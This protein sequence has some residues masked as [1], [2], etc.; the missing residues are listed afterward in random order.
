MKN[1]KLI[2]VMAVLSCSC[3]FGLANTVY[4]TSH[5]D[6]RALQTDLSQICEVSPTTN[7]K[8]STSNRGEASSFTMNGQVWYAPKYSSTDTIPFYRLNSGSDHMDS[9]LAGEG[10]FATEGVLAYPWKSTAKPA[11]TTNIFRGNNTS[12]SDH[13]LMSDYLIFPGYTREYIQNSYAYPRFG[14]NN[15]L[16]SLTGTEISLNSNLNTGGAV[17]EYWWNGKQF[18]DNFDYG[19]EM[20]SAIGFQA[21]SDGNPTEAGDSSYDTNKNFMHG[22]PIA[23]YSNTVNSS[24]K[25]QSTRA[26]PLE[27]NYRNFNGNQ[28][29]VPVVYKDIKLGKD[30]TIDDASLNLGTG[31]DNLKPKVAK[32]ETFVNTSTAL[33]NADTEIPTAYLKP[34][35]NR[36]FSFD[37]TVTD[38]NAATTEINSFDSLGGG[39]YHKQVNFA[40]SGGVIFANA[41]LTHA[42]GIYGSTPA[43]GGSASYFTLWKF[44]GLT[45][46]SVVKMSAAT[47]PMTVPVGE[48]KYTTR[49]VVGTLDD[50]RAAM[51]RLYIQNYR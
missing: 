25:T 34:E 3:V 43:T 14:G 10:G 50:V 15:S 42:M 23:S 1:K 4:A 30:I 49:V 12:I 17:W 37:A 45:N 44:G 26:V 46:P 27:W 29:D 32:Y 36:A 31:F 20:Q 5:A 19:R 38:I 40:G 9:D 47:G 24:A 7:D 11:G 2:S 16:Y 33:T 41:S 35:F 51:R 21:D 13:S 48:T 39:T 18:L 28:Q 8:M 22:S 6:L